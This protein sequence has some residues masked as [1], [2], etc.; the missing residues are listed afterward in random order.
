MDKTSFFEFNQ[1]EYTDPVDIEKLNDNMDKIDQALFAGL[2]KKKVTGNS[3][4]DGTQVGSPKGWAPYFEIKNANESPVVVTDRTF[5]TTITIA[6]GETHREY[7]SGLYPMNFIAADDKEVEYS[8][9]ID[10]ETRIN[11]IEP[12]GGGSVTSVT[13]N[14]QNN[15]HLTTS[16]SPIVDSGTI[17]IGVSSGYEIPE[18]SK[19]TAWDSKAADIKFEINS[20]TYVL[21]A[22]LKDSSG[23]LIGTE[24][25][26]D[27]PLETMVVDGE[28]DSTTQKIKLELK[29][30]NYVEFSVAD[31]VSGLQ[32]ELS[33]SNKLDP[34]YI[35]YD[36]THSAVTD[37]EKTTWNSK[38]DALTFD[39][40][41][42]SGSDNPVKSSGVYSALSSKVDVISGKGLSTEDYTTAEKNKL[43][44]IEANAN[45][46]T[47][48]TT[49]GNKHIP[50]G[51][52]SG[53]ILGWSADGEAMWVDPSG[54]GG[55]DVS[56]IKVGST[57]YNPDSSGIVSLPA[58]PTSLPAS[59]VYS[60]AKASSKPSYTYSEVGAAASSH[61]HSGYASSSH[62][63]SNYVKKGSYTDNMTSG[64]VN[65]CDDGVVYCTSNV[66]GGPV[67]SVTMMVQTV[68]DY[69]ENNKT[70]IATV[71]SGNYK[72]K[73]YSRYCVSG[74]WS[75][76]SSAYGA[77][78]TKSPSGNVSSASIDLSDI[79]CGTYLVYVINNESGTNRYGCSVYT[80]SKYDS[81]TL[82]VWTP[83]YEKTNSKVSSCT[84]SGNTMSLTFDKS[85]Y[86]TIRLK[87]QF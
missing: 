65:D 51:G 56:S 5:S 15:S 67:S 54:G 43:S 24:R 39:S 47:H 45:N 36:S 18:T 6:A 9:F 31:L 64:S 55:G 66:T 19:Q 7:I 25:T 3:I 11:E 12:S 16:G 71:L 74:T 68:Y 76:W 37:A 50:S 60:W 38:Q 78:Y 61:S 80:L 69:S 33:A 83:V 84:F 77:E 35:D 73:T 82:Y 86:K 8:Y 21:T 41:P 59:D 20:S 48:P 13:V 87:N 53:K 1:P 26:I 22:Q 17:T 40:A 30:G 27:L 28:Y 85:G 23:N 32:T 34:D 57:T 52:S 46:Y 75:A 10:A 44:G 58:Y 70:Q 49:S 79:A 62:S 63:H 72:G 42:I 81:G 4:G 2:C 29:N 14:S